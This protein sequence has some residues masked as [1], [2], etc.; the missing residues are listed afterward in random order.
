MSGPPRSGSLRALDAMPGNEPGAPLT[1]LSS[2][3][4]WGCSAAAQGDQGFALA[5]LRDR[6]SE[7]GPFQ[8]DTSHQEGT[9]M[10]RSSRS[11]TTALW[12]TLALIASSAATIATIATASPAEASGSSRMIHAS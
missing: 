9:G 12:S 7:G 10:D 2:G 8:P 11:R 4:P 3:H 6:R 5:A 1:L